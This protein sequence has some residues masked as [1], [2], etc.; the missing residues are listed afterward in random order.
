[1]VAATEQIERRH[2]EGLERSIE[3]GPVAGGRDLADG[4][5]LGV[6]REG[7]PLRPAGVADEVVGARAMPGPPEAKRRA[8]RLAAGAEQEGAAEAEGHRAPRVSRQALHRLAGGHR[9]RQVG[10]LIHRRDAGVERA[11]GVRPLRHPLDQGHAAGDEQPRAESPAVSVQE[12]EPLLHHQRRDQ[13]RGD[14][15]GRDP[16]RGGSGVPHLVTGVAARP[17]R[18]LARAE[19]AGDAGPGARSLDEDAAV[20]SVEAA[21]D[22]RDAESP[23]RPA[24]GGAGLG[25]VDAAEDEVDPPVDAAAELPRDVGVERE[26]GGPGRQSEGPETLGGDRDLPASLVAA[27]EEHGAA[28]VGRGA[29]LHPGGREALVR[30]DRVLAPD[31]E[32]V[33]AAGLGAGEKPLLDEL[34]DDLARGGVRGDL[35]QLEVGVVRR[36]HDREPEERRRARSGL[37]LTGRGDRRR[38]GAGPGV[39]RLLHQVAPSGMTAGAA[40]AAPLGS[41]A[42]AES[43]ALTVGTTES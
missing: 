23:G 11:A 7:A 29:A 4:L 25:G 31:R 40:V 22:R 15:G 12:P 26:D 10:T 18:P 33:G 36:R 43:T 8:A 6:A 21:E 42:F 2:A 1:L 5:D 17:F 28:Q 32:H 30:V 27:A 39:Q 38:R 34:L 14:L 41:A 20:V 9:S 19:A 24:D 16:A 35:G 3:Q 37:L 13:G